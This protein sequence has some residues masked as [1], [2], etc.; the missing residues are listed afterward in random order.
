MPE[1]K[2]YIGCKLI[3]AHPDAK[4]GKEGYSVE[5]ADGYKSWSPKETFE[6]AYREVT[7]EEKG[8]L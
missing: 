8:M 4:D 6:L 5:Y 2:L 3:K 7:A 1:T